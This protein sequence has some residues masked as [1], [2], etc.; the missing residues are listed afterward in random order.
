MEPARQYSGMLALG[1]SNAAP[2]TWNARQ[3]AALVHAQGLTAQGLGHR[4]VHGMMPQTFNDIT[5]HA[6]AQAYF[7]GL[8]QGGARIDGRR[9]NNASRQELVGIAEFGAWLQ[10]LPLEWGRTLYT[11]V[12]EDIV[13]YMESHWVRNHGR[14]V[15]GNDPTLM[16]SASGAKGHLLGLEH[17]FAALGRVGNWNPATLSGNPCRSHQVITWRRGYKRGQWIAGVRPVA[18]TPA[19]ATHIQQLTAP[20]AAS[21]AATAPGPPPA[22]GSVQHAMRVRDDGLVFY[23]HEAGQRA[24]EV[25]HMSLNSPIAK[26]D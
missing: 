8:A 11:A 15:V 7:A 18:A 19:T 10:H 5:P 13:A 23:L 6:A 4:T 2:R 17:Y 21:K 1:Q 24:G 25:R 20:A 22:E 3:W 16:A 9:D 12:P 26:D 14:T